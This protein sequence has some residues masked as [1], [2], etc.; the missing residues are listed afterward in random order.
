MIV[1]SFNDKSKISDKNIIWSKNVYRNMIITFSKGIVCK[2]LVSNT[3]IKMAFI[4]TKQ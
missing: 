3:Y 1:F 2:G 4:I